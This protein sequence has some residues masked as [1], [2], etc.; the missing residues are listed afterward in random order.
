V[1]DLDQPVNVVLQTPTGAV[2]VESLNGM[3]LSSAIKEIVEEWEEA[4]QRK[5]AVLTDDIEL[6]WTRSLRS[7]IILTSRES[8]TMEDLRQ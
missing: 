2:A 7:T 3:S 1:V 6:R 8:D 5:V 4:D